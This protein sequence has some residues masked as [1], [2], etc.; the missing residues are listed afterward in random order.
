MIALPMIMPLTI[1]LLTIAQMSAL[2]PLMIE[3]VKN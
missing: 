2:M 3:A 1:V